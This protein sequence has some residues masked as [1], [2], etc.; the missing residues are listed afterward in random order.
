MLVNYS[1]VALRK[2]HPEFGELCLFYLHETHRARSDFYRAGPVL[3][4]GLGSVNEHGLDLRWRTVGH[5]RSGWLSLGILVKKSFLGLTFGSLAIMSFSAMAQQIDYSQPSLMADQPDTWQPYAGATYAYDDNLFRI[6][7][8]QSNGSP[9]SDT[10]WTR[11]AGLAFDRVYSRQHITANIDVSKTT[12]DRFNFI[13][14][15]GKDAAVN[16]NW[17][18]TNDFTGNIGII[19]SQSLT[20][21]TQFHLAELNLRDQKIE[22]VDGTWHLTPSWQIF[23]SLNNYELNYDLL[24]QQPGNREIHTDNVGFNYVSA[25]G[26]TIG[27]VAQR[28]E[29]VFPV[30]QLIGPYFINN[31]YTQDELRGSLDWMISGLTHIEFL[32]GWARRSYGEFAER[33]VSGPSVRLLA[34]YI[35]TGKTNINMNVWRD[36]D[37]S[38]NLTIQYS[39]DKGVS[40]TPIWDALPRVRVQA[41][42]KRETFDYTNSTLTLSPLQLNRIDTMRDESLSAEYTP[43]RKLQASLVVY[44]DQLN[45]TI[46]SNNYRDKGLMLN[47]HASF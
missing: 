42:L 35:A 7:T 20:P 17:G 10:S 2:A 14:Y 5:R 44:A 25:Q 19:Y 38:D 39:I 22:N 3:N 24:S 15:D 37:E 27:L 21:F 9:T 18:V 45:S 32:G 4:D 36:I 33:D 46:S 47:V 29:G 28:E 26:N 6:P 30:E 23:G 31:N 43:L 40:I 12:F 8:S 16:W 11:E 1:G 13:D 34:T 41:M